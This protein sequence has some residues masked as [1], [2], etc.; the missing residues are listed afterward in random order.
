MNYELDLTQIICCLKKFFYFNEQ[1]NTIFEGI[2]TF[3]KD[4]MTNMRLDENVGS[5]VDFKRFLSDYT[6]PVTV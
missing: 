6:Q 4:T 2:N 5:E 1:E 3:K